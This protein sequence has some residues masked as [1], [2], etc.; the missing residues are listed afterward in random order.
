M[1]SRVCNLGMY[2]EP[3]GLDSVMEAP[4]IVPSVFAALMAHGCVAAYFRHA[5]SAS[6]TNFTFAKQASL[7]PR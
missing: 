2:R 4:A 5:A 3:S 6:F 7:D 1:R